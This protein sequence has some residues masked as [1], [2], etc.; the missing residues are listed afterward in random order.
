MYVVNRIT[1]CIQNKRP[2]SFSKYGD[3]EYF[4]AFN[5][6]GV[7]NHNCDNDSYTE[8]KGNRLLSSFKY[9]V[10]NTDNA[11]IGMWHNPEQ[12][13]HWCKLIDNSDLIKWTEYHT[14]IID[15]NDFTMVQIL[16]DKI[17]MYKSIQDSSLTKVIVCNPLLLKAQHFLKIDHMINVPLNNW[18]DT[19]FD[20]LL[21]EIKTKIGGD[22]QPLVITCC[23]MGAKVL[24]CELTK[25]Y[26]NGIFLDFGSALDF[27][28][29]RRDS[30]G[31]GYS[32]EE[33]CSKMSSILP[34]D[35]HNEKYN[36]IYEQARY[37][38]GIH[39]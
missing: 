27:I 30:R 20:N 2:I 16:E 32:Y 4:C 7:G 5:V 28:C 23:G 35:W 12:I 17:R 39:I 33:L 9:M 6:Q 1:E 24:I 31:R 19:Q 10:E 8:D 22:T 13:P 37:N 18:F 36:F 25:I 14:F 11:Y 15:H 26:P 34:N 29:T 38:L 21:E 3:G